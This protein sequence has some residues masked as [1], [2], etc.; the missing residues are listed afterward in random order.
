MANKTQESARKRFICQ[1]FQAY[2]ET[3]APIYSKNVARVVK[4]NMSK[5]CVVMLIH[6]AGVSRTNE[7]D[8]QAL[9]PAILRIGIS[10]S[11]ANQRFGSAAE[12]IV[13]CNCSVALL[14]AGGNDNAA[15]GLF[16]GAAKGWHQGDVYS[17][18]AP[19]T[20]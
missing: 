19:P 10:L 16:H 4:T 2:R 9:A 15:L 14:S 6:C 20:R 3:E 8:E 18:L 11:L 12:S 17:R 13:I 5:P 1:V 7:P